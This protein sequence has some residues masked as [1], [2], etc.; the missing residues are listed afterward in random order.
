VNDPILNPPAIVK[1]AEDADSYFKQA[2]ACA[3]RIVHDS[4][5]CGEWLIKAKA[6]CAHG[7]WLP[8]LK[9]YGFEPRTAQR[10]MEKAKRKGE[11]RQLSHLE[12]D[13]SSL[14]VTELRQA[15][16]VRQWADEGV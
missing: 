2:A 5:A 10:L 7:Q 11:I 6:S 16:W 9:E 4:L 8:K 13:V 12:E 14:P 15:L 1:Q 3:K